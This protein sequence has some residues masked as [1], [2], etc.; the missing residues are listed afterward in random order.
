MR[1][2]DLMTK[3]VSCV[4]SSESLSAAAR[5]MW[6]CDCGSLPVIDEASRVVGMITDRDI[7]MAAY[8]QGVPLCSIRVA[9]IMS[10]DPCTVAAET[11]LTDAERLM[12]ERQVRRLPV[13]DLAGTNNQWMATEM[14]A[15]AVPT[16]FPA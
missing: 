6:D 10:R 14:P 1:V 9:D 12:R 8:F 7:C 3:N 5:L 4:R 2:Q 13:V 11:G 15:S 16:S